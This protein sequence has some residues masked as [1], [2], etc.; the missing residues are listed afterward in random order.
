MKKKR[1][2]KR[3]DVSWLLAV[4]CL[5]L[6]QFWWLPGD[7]GTPDDS[8]SNAIEGKR[9]LYETLASLS[10][11]GMFPEVRRETMQL[12]PERP[13][14]L[15]LLSPDRYPNEHETSELDDFVRRGG[16][17]LFAPNWSD[18]ECSVPPLR[19]STEASFFAEESTVSTT[20]APVT[21]S[22]SD[23]TPPGSDDGGLQLQA[24][25]P[26][27]PNSA[28]QVTS[29]P[30]DPPNAEV[31]DTQQEAQPGGIFSDDAKSDMKKQPGL[32]PDQDSDL[33]SDDEFEDFRTTELRTNSRLVNG[34]VPWRTRATMNPP[35]GMQFTSLVESAGGS[36]QAAS[37]TIGAG[38]VVVSASPDVF[39]NAA[40]LDETQ[41][42]LAIRLVEHA[43]TH[44][45]H[46]GRSDADVVVNEF[47]NSSDAYRGTAVLMS[48]A[49]RSG[50]LQLVM[51]GIMAGWCGFHRFGPAIKSK[52]SQRRSLTDSAVAV[53]NLQFRA[54]GGAA[55]VR[56]YVDYVRTQLRRVHG[57]SLRLEDVEA[58]SHRSGI[59]AAEIQRRVANAE[60]HA[61]DSTS[62]S[63][64][65][66]A[67]IRELADLQSRLARGMEQSA[68]EQ[69]PI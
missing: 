42:E 20:V 58:V 3:S 63:A 48:P 7:P 28:E 51:I 13:C 17:L 29:A 1:R 34:S 53:G 11:A 36:V 60:R 61:Q 37:W 47:L 67:A 55:S 45:S 69:K 9:G 32:L 39:S 31:S 40:M 30:N 56:A 25:A 38:L 5:I 62:S 54:K 8:Y 49:L 68:H 59:E 24:E 12:I 22:P 64:A 19:I 52:V 18:P 35:P 57:N 33:T 41:A 14:T 10:A 2:L 26:S 15:L 6:L 46:Q 16:T 44:H 43:H 66:A 65:V 23:E 21:T 50:T 4:G 27:Q